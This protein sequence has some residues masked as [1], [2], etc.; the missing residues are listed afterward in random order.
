[1]RGRGIYVATYPLDANLMSTGEQL[2]VTGLL[3]RLSPTRRG[4][5]LPPRGREG[6][7]V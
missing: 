2:E 6:V 5:R 7:T 4:H 1:M 3:G